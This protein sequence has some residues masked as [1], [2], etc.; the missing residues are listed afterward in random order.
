MS[1]SSLSRIFN[2][3]LLISVWLVFYVIFAFSAGL[4]EDP[5]FRFGPQDTF[6]LLGKPINTW[7]KYLAILAIQVVDAVLYYLAGLEVFPW[8]TTDLQDHRLQYY[9]PPLWKNYFI[10]NVYQIQRTVL[11]IFWVFL[12]LA[13]VDV[14]IFSALTILIILNFSTLPKF[15]AHKKPTPASNSPSNRFLPPNKF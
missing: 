4:L 10:V 7:D 5:Y 3:S 12:A 1:Q 11:N 8:I 14:A 13:Q 6:L 15:L 2:L 9:D